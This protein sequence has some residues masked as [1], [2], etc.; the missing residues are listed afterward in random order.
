MDSAALAWIADR[1]LSSQ[2][3]TAAKGC[4][5]QIQWLDRPEQV[6]AAARGGSSTRFILDVRP[7]HLTAE[8]VDVL[9]EL[10]AEPTGKIGVLTLGSSDWPFSVAT[11]CE[12][13]S[14]GHIHCRVGWPEEELQLAE[15]RRFLQ[16]KGVTARHSFYRFD[17][18]AGEYVTC[19]TEVATLYD[20]VER[21]SQCD[22]TLLLTG[23]SGT[24]KS[25]VARAIHETSVRRGRPMSHL[26]CGALSADLADSELF[27]HVR[28]AF[29]G[30]DRARTGRLAAAGTGTFLLDDVDLLSPNQQAKLLR[31]IETGEFEPVGSTET[32]T[33]TARILATSNVDLGALCRSGAFRTDLYYRLN[34]LELELLPLRQR[35]VDIPLL[36]ATMLQEICEQQGR[37]IESISRDVFRAFC[38]YDW[39]GNLRELRNVLQ[40]AILFADAGRITTHQLPTA[41]RQAG[42]RP[43]QEPSSSQ[44]PGLMAQHVAVTEKELLEQTLRDCNYNR[45]RTALALGIS[46]AGLYKRMERLGISLPD[47][48]AG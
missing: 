9:K 39:P 46:R 37:R 25:T 20:R 30:A 11:H 32:R 28:G 24:G 5:R 3:R 13:L 27:G 23:E 33:C 41:I 15:L 4:E 14:R 21:V 36:A 1:E 16:G 43:V 34:V 19:S 7:R 26:A 42:V 12:I 45:S 38:R 2:L 10:L 8:I 35:L 22:A 40:R 17:S 31:V 47:R 48:D 44:T 6:V 18:L 29:P